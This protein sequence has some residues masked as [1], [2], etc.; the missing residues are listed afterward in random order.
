MDGLERTWSEQV[1]VLR[2]DV[3]SKVGQELA[4]RYRIRALPTLILIAEDKEIYRQEGFPNRSQ[5]NQILSQV[6]EEE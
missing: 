6:V 1:S 4:L 2:L 5:W 3:G